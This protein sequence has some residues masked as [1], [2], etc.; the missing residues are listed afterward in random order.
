MKELEYRLKSGIY[1]DGQPFVD[2]E[3]KQANWVNFS[4]GI[5]SQNTTKI[6]EYVNYR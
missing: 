4:K 1:Y 5:L 3:N 2:F 6:S